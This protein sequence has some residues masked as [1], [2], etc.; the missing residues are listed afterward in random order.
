MNI[1]AKMDPK[2][3]PKIDIWTLRGQTFEILGGLLWSKIFD[4]FLIGEKSAK[5]L[6][7]GGLGRPR[8]ECAQRSAAEAVASRGSWN[9]TGT[10][11]SL[12]RVPNALLPARGAA[13]LKA[14]TSAADPTRTR[15]D[16][17]RVLGEKR[18][19]KSCRKEGCPKKWDK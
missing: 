16:E 13:D 2:S 8:G 11:N 9:L 6:K 5:S 1:Y 19:P 4:G 18:Y 15:V 3:D 7:I 14:T 12:T 17:V 10:G